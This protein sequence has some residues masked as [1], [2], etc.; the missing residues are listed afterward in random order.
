MARGSLGAAAA[1]LLAALA[2][3]ADDQSAPDLAAA[4]GGSSPACAD[5]VARAPQTV[6]DRTRT[7]PQAIGVAAWGEPP[8]VLQCGV[9]VA[10]GPTS[11]P[12]Y[13][14]DGVDWINENPEAGDQPTAF[15]T[16]G[17]DPAVRVTVPGPREDAT[18]ALVDLAPAV[19]PLPASKRCD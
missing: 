9:D 11:D 8:I 16:Y 2:G 7:T 3:C 14:V 13:A 15:V 19:S 12:C 4:P 17:R 10:D 18:A 5:V 1:L 6:L